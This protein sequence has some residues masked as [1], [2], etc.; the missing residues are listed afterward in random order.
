MDQKSELLRSLPLVYEKSGSMLNQR[1]MDVLWLAD[2]QNKR[3]EKRVI[4]S[5]SSEILGLQAEF[6]KTENPEG[7][8][9][10]KLSIGASSYR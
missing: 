1:L 6:G 9:S 3:S 2:E 4:N 8:L 10:L 7:I 5:Y